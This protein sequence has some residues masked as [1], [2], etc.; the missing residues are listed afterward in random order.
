MVAQA[1]SS[2]VMFLRSPGR[3]SRSK[4]STTVKV[5][6]RE[7]EGIRSNDFRIESYYSPFHFPLILW[8]KV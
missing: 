5:S 3:V 8:L 6:L 7:A 4:N 1:H 2:L